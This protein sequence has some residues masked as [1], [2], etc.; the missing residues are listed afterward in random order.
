MADFDHDGVEVP[1][2][3]VAVFHLASRRVAVGVACE[4]DI[5]PSGADIVCESD[6]AVG[7]GVNGIAKVGVAAGAAIP[8]FTE[9]LGCAE[10]KATR[11]VVTGGIGFT[12]GKVE[13]IC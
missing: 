9:V 13:A 11:F 2:E 1:V 5:S 3:R 8:I 4:N 12:D 7:D 10:A 6:D